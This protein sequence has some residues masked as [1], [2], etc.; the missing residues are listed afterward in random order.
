MKI[1]YKMWFEKET[2]FL[3]V[4]ESPMLFFAWVSSCSSYNELISCCSAEKRIT[5]IRFFVF[6]IGNVPKNM[7]ILWENGKVRPLALIGW[8]IRN[9]APDLAEKK[10]LK[11]T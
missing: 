8:S 7:I 9:I 1:F 11:S 2:D 10:S 4:C 3:L 6:S 5:K